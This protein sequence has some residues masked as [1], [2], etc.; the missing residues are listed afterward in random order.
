MNNHQSSEETLTQETEKA[1]EE[2]A[3]IS[4]WTSIVPRFKG[5]LCPRDYK[6][7]DNI[8]FAVLFYPLVPLIALLMWG[9]CP[10]SEWLA[11]VCRVLFL[12]AICYLAF[13]LIYMPLLNLSHA[14]RRLRH[15]GFSNIEIFVICFLLGPPVAYGFCLSEEKP[16]WWKNLFN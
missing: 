1:Q 16:R 2:N 4:F 10:E 5:K 11:K 12:L 6:R 15:A 14:V 3:P 7:A 13:A 8:A 9:K